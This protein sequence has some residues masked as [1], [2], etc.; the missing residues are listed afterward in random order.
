MLHIGE[1]V[2]RYGEVATQP[3]GV[4]MVQYFQAVLYE[5]VSVSI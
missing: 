2:V 3:F 1:A 4:P 5:I